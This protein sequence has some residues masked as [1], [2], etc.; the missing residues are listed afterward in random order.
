MLALDVARQA[1][2][3]LDNN[4]ALALSKNATKSLAIIGLNGNVTENM[5]SN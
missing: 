3:L 2:V 5:I 1:I 4:G